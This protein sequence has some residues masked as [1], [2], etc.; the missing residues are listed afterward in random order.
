MTM[1]PFA[2]SFS[3]SLRTRTRS[4]SGVMFT[5]ISLTS[6]QSISESSNRQLCRAGLL[7]TKTLLVLLPRHFKIVGFLLLTLSFSL[8]FLL[9]LE[10]HG[11]GKGHFSFGV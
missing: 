1:P 8:R 4:C 6:V 7:R 3:S 10:F 9:F 2:V 5:V 11:F